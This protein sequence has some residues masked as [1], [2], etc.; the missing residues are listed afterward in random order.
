VADIVR[1]ILVIAV[2]TGQFVLNG[3]AGQ[4]VP[5]VWDFYDAC[6]QQS[7]SFTAMVECGKQKRTAFCT[8]KN[9]CSQRGDTFVQYADALALAVTNREISEAQARLRYAEY[10]TQAMNEMQRNA[11]IIAAGAAASGPNTCIV[12]GNTV[13]C[14]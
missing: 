6:A 1:L 3:C 10:K 7:S 2:L 12:N 13:N 5:Y 14:F 9:A 11:A 4:H 8:A